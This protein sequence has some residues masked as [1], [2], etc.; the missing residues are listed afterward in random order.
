MARRN[1]DRRDMNEGWGREE[2]NF[3][4]VTGKPKLQNEWTE[5]EMDEDG[6]FGFEEGEAVEPEDDFSPE[7]SELIDPEEDYESAVKRYEEQE[8]GKPYGSDFGFDSE[9]ATSLLRLIEATATK[10]DKKGLWQQARVIDD[11]LV[12]VAA[13]LN[14]MRK[15]AMSKK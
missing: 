3:D 4:V 2:E 6:E 15:I 13:K 8:I 12:R 1:V 10:L 7:F 5:R 14:T 9:A 11:V